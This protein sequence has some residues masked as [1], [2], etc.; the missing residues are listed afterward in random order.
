VE[1]AN[2]DANNNSNSNNNNN[3]TTNINENA[4]YIVYMHYTQHILNPRVIEKCPAASF[5]VT[6]GNDIIDM[7]FDQRTK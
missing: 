4:E 5:V 6:L 7:V 1:L 2:E 3:T